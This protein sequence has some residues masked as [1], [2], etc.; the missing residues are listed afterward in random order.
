MKYICLYL[1]IVVL[2]LNSINA[3]NVTFG[4]KGGL[5]L[6]SIDR[7]INGQPDPKF[8][9][10]F[11]IGGFVEAP[12]WN[13]FSLQPE[14]LYSGQGFRIKYSDEVYVQKLNYLNLPILLKYYISE[15]LSVETGPQMGVLIS[16]NV[17]DYEKKIDFAIDFGLAYKME[18][19]LGF[20]IRYNF[21]LSYF[22]NFSNSDSPPFNKHRVFQISVAYIF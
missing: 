6:A 4:V 22:D 2:G 3:Q 17:S 16:S 12:L 5:N 1:T 13:K 10:S 18:M 11:H 14:L 7:Y 20:G 8:R 19:G 9:T 15:R 21:G